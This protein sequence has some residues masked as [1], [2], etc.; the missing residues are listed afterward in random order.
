MRS[1]KQLMKEHRVTHDVFY[2]MS[3]KEKQEAFAK[4]SRKA[5]EEHGRIFKGRS[6]KKFQDESWSNGMSG[7][8]Q[9][10]STKVKKSEKGLW[11]APPAN[12]SEEVRRTEELWL[13]MHSLPKGSLPS[14]RKASEEPE[15][16]RLARAAM[17]IPWGN[18]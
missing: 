15:P 7:V 9:A 2:F 13:G 16:T 1:C 11:Q 3:S 14:T 10:A 5:L 8:K 17:A 12:I 18:D 6:T 4:Y